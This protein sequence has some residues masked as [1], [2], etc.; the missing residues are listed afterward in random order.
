MSGST[1]FS[2]SSRW[3]DLK[4][5][6]RTIRRDLSS[7]AVR[8]PSSFTFRSLSPDGSV[9]R[10]YFLATTQL[11]RETTLLYVDLRDEGAIA[12]SVGEKHLIWNSLI[13]PSFQSMSA[14]VG[15]VSKEEELQLERK[16]CVSWGITSYEI[17]C[18]SGSF[19]F[20]AAG[21]LFGAIDQISDQPRIFSGPSSSNS[22]NLLLPYEI[23]SRNDGARLNPTLCP[24][25]PDLLA[26]I[27]NG[28][29][30]VT[31][32]P[33]GQEMQLTFCH[34]GQG[35]L[36]DDPLI[37]G[38]PS[39][40][41]QEE[42]SRFIG[43][44]WRPIQGDITQNG[45]KYCILYEEVD[46]SE[47]EV[48]KF[49]TVG[50]T[51]VEEFRFPKAGSVNSRSTLKMVQFTLSNSSLENSNI[52]T[53]DESELMTNADDSMQQASS[54]YSNNSSTLLDVQRYELSF[55]LETFF[56]WLEYIVRI[57]WTPDGHYVWCQLL[58]RPQQLLVI[59]LIPIT[60]FLPQSEIIS[61]GTLLSAGQH[62]MRHMSVEVGS[63]IPASS[64]GGL[65]AR[66]HQQLKSSTQPPLQVIYTCRSETWITVSDILTF[67]ATKPV[68]SYAPSPSVLG[69]SSSTPQSA[70]V[71]TS[72]SPSLGVSLGSGSEYT[73]HRSCSSVDHSSQVKFI[74]S[75]EES[76]WR[77]LYLITA[78]LGQYTEDISPERFAEYFLRPHIMS[79]V[80]LT[81]GPWSVID[82]DIW[83][84]ETNGFVYFHGLRETPLE[85]HLYV[86]S[87]DQPCNVRR[88]TTSGYSHTAHLNQECT[89]MVTSFSSIHSPPATQLYRIRKTDSTV[90]GIV[91]SPSGW[92][93]ETKPPEKQ[94]HYPELFSHTISSG[95][96]LYGMVFKP[97]DIQMGVKYPI[98]LS[99]YGGPE[100]QLVSNTFKGM[101]QMRNH[102]LASEGYCV[103][104]IDSRGS[105]NRG[106]AFEAHLR[107]RM[108]Q[109]ELAD[110]VEVLRWLGSVT[111]YMDLTR[112][113]IHGWSYGGYLSLMG[114][115]K[116]PDLFK[117][118][119]AGAPVTTWKLYDTGYTER[120]M[121]LPSNNPLG[122]KLGSILHY[123][124]DFP[125]EPNRLLIVHG[126]MDENVHFYQHTAQLLSA[127]V[128]HGKP[129]QLQIYPGERHSLRRLEA[130]EQY[131]T[132]LLHFLQSNL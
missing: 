54:S 125:D 48:M 128:R 19:I 61:S 46:E 42:F 107:H 76:G 109:V 27:Y 112:I 38:L 94:Y 28:N 15:R 130:S 14:S 115:I 16:R 4:S 126:L 18:R 78:H 26:Y 132:T 77:H 106:T 95:D 120:Y 25:N 10:L 75:T 127:L 57:G 20:P 81:Q 72:S 12:N 114:L 40:V 67:C 21:T 97:H 99:V 113:G 90:E 131:E 102:L 129:Y 34:Q 80:A 30:W 119:V 58:D 74:F 122:Y 45:K 89:L 118:C 62:H 71:V 98:I 43:F 35:S 92:L 104:S 23:K 51:D 93:H 36:V 13:E 116:Y 84:D 69:L 105:H 73:Y 29:I 22:S 31:H 9:T 39:Y 96:K 53:N 47:V 108:G 79:K 44:W 100:V 59:V 87:I 24:S 32:I 103:V 117:V 33:T 65:D 91:L 2:S 41:T 8:V 11:G 3:T 17:D 1:T 5:R 55:T 123:A 101:R 70:S 37:A 85:K 60:S 88:L 124:N 7:L 56:P 52:T 86:V 121:D 111:N 83:F 110:Q 50:S 66:T 63:S 6:V 64:T 82:K 68:S 49:P